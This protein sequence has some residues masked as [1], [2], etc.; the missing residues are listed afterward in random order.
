MSALEVKL[1][2]IGEG[3]AEG[4]V[5]QWLVK[6]GETVQLEQTLVEILTDKAA[7]EIPSPQQGT[8]EKILVTEGDLVPVG[9]VIALLETSS[10]S[11]AVKPASGVQPE[12]EQTDSS[13]S[14]VLSIEKADGNILAAPS[15]R[16]LAR[17][18]DVNL[19]EV[20]GSGA[21][22]RILRQDLDNY[23]EQKKTIVESTPA[24]AQI[25]SP[26][27]QSDERI[28]LRGIRRRISEHMTRSKQTIPEFMFADEADLT[29]LVEFRQ[30]VK[31]SLKAEG[32]KL[33][34][35][36][37]FVKAVVAA[38]KK[39]PSLNASL[40]EEKQEIILK[41]DYNIGIAAST[42]RGLMVPVIH[43]AD[44]LSLVEIAKK[45]EELSQAARQGKIKPEHL[46]NGT[47]TISNVGKLGGIMAIPIINHPEVAI[48][49]MNKIQEKPVAY[50][51]E[52]AI[53]WMTTLS[54]TFDHRVIDGMD[55]ALFTRHIIERLE[56]PKLLLLE[57]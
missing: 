57:G 55:G 42:E 43:H 25:S 4:E 31:D 15:T 24:I 44:Q 29:E 39:Y 5:V 30:S 12:V 49:G 28:P 45:I 33:T 7:V 22:G 40:D 34:Y 38:L 32:I 51:G 41:K 3:I 9:S 21:Y 48:L 16:R 11:S 36:A 10:G 37:F 2:D 46:K 35:L 1:P 20:K 17:Q 14:S 18:N 26:T 50:Q 52:I 19:Q 54:L 6:E 53:R 8:L 13:R 47:F 56:N 23:L 27:R